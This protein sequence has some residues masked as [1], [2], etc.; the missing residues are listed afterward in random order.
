MSTYSHNNKRAVET[1]VVA[2][3]AQETMPVNGTALVNPSTGGINLANNQLG[4]FQAFPYDQASGIKT[5]LTAL[6][7]NGT[8]T[9]ATAP[10]IQIYQGTEH[11]ANPGGGIATYPLSVRAYKASE[12]IIGNNLDSIMKQEAV[13]PRPSVWV[14]GQP[15]GDAG[16]IVIQDNTE[17]TISIVERGVDANYFYTSDASNKYAP[18]FTTPDYT[19]LATA[20]PRDHMIQHLLYE[21]NRNSKRLAFNRPRF[22]GDENL[23]ALAIDTA[24][25]NGGVEIGG[26]TPLAAGDVIPVVNTNVGV[27]NI[28][29]SEEQATAIKDAALAAFGG[30]I[31]D[32]T[33]RIL[34]IDLATAGTV[35][36]GIADTIML[37]SLDRDLMWQD[38]VAQTKTRLDVALPNGFDYLTT[39]HQQVVTPTE[40]QG[41]PRQLDLWWRATEGQRLYNLRHSKDPIINYP[42]P[43]ADNTTY[44]QYLIRHNNIKQVDVGNVVVGP[45][46][47]IALVPTANTALITLMD[48]VL[49]G[50]ATSANGIGIT[51]A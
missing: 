42:S 16:E 3:T 7:P 28:T 10:H 48:T 2:G 47:E 35:T 31:A 6:N 18:S 25:L 41:Q 20:Q 8:D 23:F 45:K 37:V 9:V 30:V 17:Y 32:L 5:H 33:A 1:F 29:L 19:A 13:A 12:V 44:T 39:Y 46:L 15:A 27:R 51:G 26:L 34:T 11:S 4:I 49:G 21:I 43:I 24:G 14:I 22:K 38:W 50:W 40:G 36:G